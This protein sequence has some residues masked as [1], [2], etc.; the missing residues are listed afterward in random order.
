MLLATLARSYAA[1]TDLV[2][3]LGCWWRASSCFLHIQN[4]ATTSTTYKLNDN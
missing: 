1:L 4:N 3:L 2:D